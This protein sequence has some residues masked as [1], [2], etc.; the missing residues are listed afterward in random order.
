VAVLLWGAGASLVPA[1][2]RLG[3][4]PGWSLLPAHQALARAPHRSALGTVVAGT[5]FRFSFDGG[6]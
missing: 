4:A 6:S 1:P 3:V 5:A 2:G